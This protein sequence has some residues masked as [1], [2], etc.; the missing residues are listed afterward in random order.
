VVDIQVYPED[1]RIA[2]GQQKQFGA[3]GQG[4]G[5]GVTWEVDGVQGGT[6][7]TGTITAEGVYTAPS[8]IPSPAQ[9]TVTAR[10]IDKPN[11]LDTATVT[12]TALVTVSPSQVRLGAGESFQFQFPG[13]RHSRHHGD[14]DR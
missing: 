3:L 6:A 5:A 4:S 10:S 12:I 13:E 1:Y 11:K 2:G 9:V 8:L 14:L 7:T